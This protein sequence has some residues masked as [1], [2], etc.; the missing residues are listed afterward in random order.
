MQCSKTFLFCSVL[1][2]SWNTPVSA[3]PMVLINEVVYDGS[4]SDADDVFTEL[5]GSP[6]A[7]LNGYF[8]TGTNGSTGLVYRS[9]DLTNTVIPFDGVLVLATSSASDAVKAARDYVASVD[10]QNGPDSIQLLDATGSIIDSL[11]YGD[12]GI[13]NSGEGM[14]ALDVPAGFSLSRD[15]FATDTNNNALDFASTF[16]PTPGTGPAILNVPEPSSWLLMTFGLISFLVTIKLRALHA[17]K[18]MSG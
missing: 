4:G 12:A 3:M 2:I 5:F 14:P 6:N 9:I 8:L 7:S 15:T 10:W 16:S 18:E 17:A 1:L 13:Y 11:Q